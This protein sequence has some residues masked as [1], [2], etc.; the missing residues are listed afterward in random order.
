MNRVRM[1]LLAGVLGASGFVTTPAQA[2]SATSTPTR[3]VSYVPS[4]GYYY[5]GYSNAAPQP[6]PL[7]YGRS[8]APA[9]VRYYTPSWTSTTRHRAASSYD[10][11]GRHDGLAR[12]WLP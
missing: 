11:T 1:L 5:G 8:I 3:R 4:G 10:P 6:A 2:Q 9:P 7:Y 12:P